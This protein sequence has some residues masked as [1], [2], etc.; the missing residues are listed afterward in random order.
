MKRTYEP[1]TL[2]CE[3]AAAGLGDFITLDEVVLDG[4]T[5]TVA[6]SIRGDAWP[7]EPQDVF[8]VLEHRVEPG[9]WRYEEADPHIAEE[10]LGTFLQGSPESRYWKYLTFDRV[11]PTYAGRADTPLGRALR[12]YE[13]TC[14]L[15]EDVAMRA[16]ERA[17]I[18]VGSGCRSPQDVYELGTL[19]EYSFGKLAAELYDEAIDVSP[20]LVDETDVLLRKSELANS[21]TKDGASDA[22]E[23]LF[24]YTRTGAFAR[25]LRRDD[26]CERLESLG[27]LLFENDRE[28]ARACL[29]RVVE[30]APMTS[31]ALSAEFQRARL[32]GMEDA[33]EGIRRLECLIERYAS[34]ADGDGEE[35]RS[36]LASARDLLPALREELEV[37]DRTDEEKDER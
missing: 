36:L 2:C 29:N 34:L 17:G 7:D 1:Y 24:A 10:V 14:H 25:G 32:E 9:G 37:S 19:V 22:L 6:L 3:P 15:C 12:V 16:L 26:A 13:A 5:H 35:I 11:F 30:A 28:T 18:L 33:A 21:S 31:L 27:V 20:A 4:V 8:F 23:L